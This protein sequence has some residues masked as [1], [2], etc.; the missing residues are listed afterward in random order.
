MT[1]GQLSLHSLSWI[2]VDASLRSRANEEPPPGRPYV[3][4]PAGARCSSFSH[5]PLDHRRF[6]FPHGA[7][8]MDL[9]K[10]RGETRGGEVGKN[11]A[12]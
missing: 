2:D 11:D 10:L 3:A 12:T 4:R 9:D 1:G 6:V 8:V 5:T 7:D